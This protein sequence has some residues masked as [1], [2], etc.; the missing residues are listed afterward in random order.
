[1]SVT[2][3]PN[4]NL[5]KLSSKAQPSESQRNMYSLSV[6]DMIY[7]LFDKAIQAEYSN[8]PGAA[9]VITP[10]K[11][12]DYQCNSA[13]SI[14]N[15][16]KAAGLKTN[17]VECANKIVANLEKN[18]LIEKC[19]VS[20]PGFINIHLSKSFAQAELRKLVVSGVKAPYVGEKKKVI[21][22]F[23][24]PNIAKEMHVGHLR[25]T[26]IGESLSRLFEFI[27]FDLLR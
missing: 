23:S 18:N 24:S 2:E 22:D 11:V 7:A 20:G 12:A 5:R 14:S 17:P 8:L 6:I 9:V 10:S 15:A 13:M 1:M 25:S 3:T 21:I 16:M 19:D 27:G 4:L 26:I